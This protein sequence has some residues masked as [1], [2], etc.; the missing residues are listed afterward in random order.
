M[1]ALHARRSELFV[2][3]VIVFLAF[4]ASIAEAEQQPAVLD[5]SV[6]GVSQAQILVAVGD[7]DVWADIAALERAGLRGLAGQRER[8]GNR[9]FVRISSLSPDVQFVLDESA[10][11][12]RLTVAAALLGRTERDLAVDRPRDMELHRVPSGFVNYGVNLTTSGTRAVSLEG[13]ISAAGALLTTTAFGSSD[14]GFLRGQT[15]LT[16]DDRGRL[17]RIVVGD[18]LGATG[19]LGGSM[20]LAGVSVS[21]DYSL[22]PYFVRYPTIGLS[23]AVMTPS[24]VEVYVNDQLVRV[25]QLPP[26]VYQLNHLPL[27]VGATDT[28]VVVRDA[29]GGQQEFNSSYYV[30][31]GALARGVQQFSYS[32]GVERL[33]PFDSSFAYGRPVLLGLHRVGLTDHLT[34]G[35]RVE[36]G[37][38]IASGGPAL[39]TRLGHAGEVEGIAAMSRANGRSGY[40]GSIA[41]E[42][43]ARPGG[44]AVAV[45]H[46]SQDYST[47]STDGV[48]DWARLDVAATLTGRVSSR[49]TVGASWQSLSYH[50]EAPNAKRAAVTTTLGIGRRA[51][52]FLSASRALIENRWETG[53][54]AGLGLSLGP[55]SAVN[56]STE[57]DR[58]DYRTS[59]DMQRALPY[60][61]GYG[62][63]VQTATGSSSDLD[64]ELR[65]QASF[66]RLA[67]RQ[68][69]MNGQSA[70]L[71][72]A[73]GGVVVIGGGVHATRPV[74]DGF[75]LVRVPGVPDVRTY[76]SHQEVGRTG[77]TGDL[78]VPGLLPYY[79]NRLSIAD[80][81][82]PVDR[83]VQ[84]NE[85]IVA[86]PYRG[87]ALALFP[88]PRPWRVS[89]RLVV[90][91]GAELVVPNNG[92]LTVVNA[93]ETIET[94]LGSDGSY[95]LEGVP[96]GDYPGQLVLG[97][98]ACNVTLHVPQSDA[99]VIYAGVA[100]CTAA[101]EGQF[102]NL[103]L[104][105][106]GTPPRP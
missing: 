103:D 31:A 7:G 93:G 68:T 60:G 90:L 79:G 25:E 38:G 24:R 95:Y 81:D 18:L 22:D 56:V 55:R 47:L 52:L 29:F 99:P 13:G 53:A 8:R 59:L 88:A 105:S 69:V 62:Y 17:N 77:R 28:R 3:V 45:R 14:R 35:G 15:A 19:A 66:G 75:A 85:M 82:V 63:R 67:V 21:R 6:N 83:D 61:T 9:E 23:G 5:L 106:G 91:Q 41:Y 70:T 57:R 64:A 71:V 40:A 96:P 101:T 37:R 11:T 78:V 89:G 51:S 4:F 100:T 43:S 42:Y 27:P 34:A 87:G 36:M 39:T 48:L 58:G 76:V 16:I 30:S 65:A 44:I 10:L 102:G 98:H 104:P 2:S 1:S 94:G 12:L 49:T 26:G 80:S 33:R 86:T 97:G 84:R 54:F 50:D 73:S 20:P 32:A 46:A 74:Q 92:V 72:D